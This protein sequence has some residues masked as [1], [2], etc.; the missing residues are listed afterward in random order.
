M[1]MNQLVIRLGLESMLAMALQVL[2]EH[3]H[4]LSG[5]ISGQIA[6]SGPTQDL[7]RLPR[8]IGALMVSVIRHRSQSI[9][10]LTSGR[11]SVACL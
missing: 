9:S 6:L 5:L 4:L 8:L 11:L 1:L 7:H 3:C 10:S 2:C